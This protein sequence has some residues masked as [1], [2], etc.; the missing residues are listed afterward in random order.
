MKRAGG[1]R[2]HSAARILHNPLRIRQIDVL[3]GEGVDRRQLVGV[4]LA[5]GA[6]DQLVTLVGRLEQD[7]QFAR[8]LHFALPMIDA[9]DLRDLRAR[10]ELALDQGARQPMGVFAVGDGGDDGD[11]FHLPRSSIRP[12][13]R[14][15]GST[16]I[17]LSSLPAMTVSD[18]ATP[19]RA[20]PSSRTRSSAPVT[21]SP[22]S[23]STML[24]D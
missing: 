17:C 1:P 2:S 21:G 3:E 4:Q 10:R 14:S 12:S 13:L 18:V 20:P 16:T 11:G 24:P 8:L 15:A 6:L 5:D 9:L 23:A 22:S 19:M 7:T